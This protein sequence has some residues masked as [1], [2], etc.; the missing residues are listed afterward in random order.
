[1]QFIILN[2]RLSNRSND[3]IFN[4]IDKLIDK[5]NKIP[6]TDYINIW[7]QRLTIKLDRNRSYNTRLCQKIYDNDIKIFDTTWISSKKIK[8]DEKLIIDE[9]EIEK[10]PEIISI[11]EASIFNYH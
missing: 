4:Y 2:Y 8:I 9:E 1:M 6:N 11:E 3:K 10:L 7:L 5:I